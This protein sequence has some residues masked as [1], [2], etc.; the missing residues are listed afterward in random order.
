MIRRSVL[1]PGGHC[2]NRIDTPLAK[3]S[4]QEVWAFLAKYRR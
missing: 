4:R 3:E 1:A 2:F